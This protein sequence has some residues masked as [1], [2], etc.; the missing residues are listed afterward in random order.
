M[1]DCAALDWHSVH[2]GDARRGV[3]ETFRR[4]TQRGATQHD[5]SCDR[6]LH[7]ADKPGN[8]KRKID[9]DVM[10]GDTYFSAT[11]YTLA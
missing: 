4:D 9:A 10:G 8:K 7:V 3:S 1:D 5:Q 11:A 2:A 6:A